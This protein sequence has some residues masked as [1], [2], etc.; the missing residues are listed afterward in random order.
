MRAHSIPFSPIEQK[1]TWKNLREARIVP[2]TQNGEEIMWEVPREL[3]AY[4]L[5]QMS[6]RSRGAF[7]SARIVPITQ[8]GARSRGRSRESS[9]HIS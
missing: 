9:Q 5:A 1:V 3:A 2:L 7:E 4:L 8:N 6:K